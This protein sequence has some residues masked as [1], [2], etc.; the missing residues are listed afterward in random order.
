L[1]RAEFL[2]GNPFDDDH[3]AGVARSKGGEGRAEHQKNHFWC[4]ILKVIK[5]E[6]MMMNLKLP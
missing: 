6:E 4:F 5:A 3:I 2:A 1:P